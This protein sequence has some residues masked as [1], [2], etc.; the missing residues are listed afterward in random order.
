[1]LLVVMLTSAEAIAATSKPTY[2]VTTTVE[3]DGVTLAGFLA[4]DFN[5]AVAGVLNINTSD[6]SIT[7]VK[8]VTPTTS[9]PTTP[10]PSTPTPSTPTP[11]TPTP[12]APTPSTPTPSTPTPSTPTPAGPNI[13]CGT[14]MQLTTDSTACQAAPGFYFES[15]TTT[16][17]ND[18]GTSCP[19]NTAS[20]A[21]SS[22][23]AA[24]LLDAGYYVLTA[25][26]A[27]Q[28][29]A[30]SYC[31]G[32][33]SVN[34]VVAPT[35]CG[36]NTFSSAVGDSTAATC[37]QCAPA[38]KS[39][40]GSTVC[41]SRCI[42]PSAD[43]GCGGLYT[44]SG[45]TTTTTGCHAN[46][47]AT[48]TAGAWVDGSST[49]TFCNDG[50]VSPGWATG[51]TAGSSVCVDNTVAVSAVACVADGST[52]KLS[53]TFTGG[54]SLSGVAP[55]A[56]D[57]LDAFLIAESRPDVNVDGTA[58]DNS[59]CTPSSTAKGTFTCT[60][61]SLDPG[62]TCTG[63]TAAPSASL[64]GMTPAFGC[65]STAGVAVGVFAGG[66]Y[67]TGD[68][69]SQVDLDIIN[70]LTSFTAGFVDYEFTFKAA[71]SS[72]SAG[73]AGYCY[74]SSTSVSCY[75]FR[76]AAGYICDGTN[77]GAPAQCNAG[78]W[79]A[80]G[81]GSCTDCPDG[82]SSSDPGG[83]SIGSCVVSA[84]YYI[85]T[86]ASDLDTPVTCPEGK[87]CP[88]GSAVGVVSNPQP[89]ACV[90]DTYSTG[91]ATTCTSCPDHTNTNEE[92]GST[93]KA[94][95]LLDAGYYVVAAGTAVQCPA[96]SYCAGGT[97]VNTVVEPTA[98]AADT[99]S[100]ALGAS[101]D[102][103][104]LECAGSSVGS[105]TCPGTSE[106]RRQLLA[107]ATSSV[108]VTFVVVAG[109]QSTATA[110]STAIV[111][112]LV[113]SNVASTVTAFN[114][115]ASLAA[116]TTITVISAPAVAPISTSSDITVSVGMTLAGVNPATF[117]PFSVAA[118][119]A[120]AAG[121]NASD[122]EVTVNDLPV[123]TTLSLVGTSSLS[124]TAK[125]ALVTSLKAAIAA[126]I[127]ANAPQTL[128]V[129]LTSSRRRRILLDMTQ[130]VTV[131]GLG[132]ST[133]AA[134][135]TVSSL[136]NTATL[137]S[138]AAAAGATGATASAP[139]ARTHACSEFIFSCVH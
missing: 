24:C 90:A 66:N 113:A 21:G 85:P 5:A 101:T 106:R 80:V 17:S 23:K 38:L 91:G 131:N 28:C 3:L 12:S 86:G 34:T 87:S 15:A 89:S 61:A 105:S 36:E 92:T 47:Y 130:P 33:T 6:I 22:T 1:M 60:G 94:A 40:Q 32:G 104:C 121:V 25:G 84:G 124:S 70:G 35:P 8:A 102:E 55:T 39:P 2:Q 16:S 107:V 59:A 64:E 43:L 127:G 30:G 99:Y 117:S 20:P 108:Q 135:A 31:A 73:L 139:G 45:D 50:T 42:H 37:T 7:S 44:F 82:S 10:A 76:P 56:T 88:G 116:V 58:F 18:V 98:C 81:A 69:V 29:T 27:V 41:L 95:C 49:C 46:S 54:E 19:Q 62:Y 48:L 57:L 68:E 118:G 128:A 114:A 67:K 109:S 138:A 134:S 52:S 110:L 115:K 74:A 122:V 4:T 120:A 96:G 137:S 11:S 103:T 78:S 63:A 93:S 75:G 97:S 129:A 132:S 133:A 26:T 125:S 100:T 136:T 111:A 77:T 13:S 112:A 119:I 51:G 79:S 83:T 72:D 71:T 53:V 126:S 65:S 9:T 123:T 14:G